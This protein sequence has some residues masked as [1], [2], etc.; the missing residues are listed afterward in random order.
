MAQPQRQPPQTGP[1]LESVQHP[2][3]SLVHADRV[4]D[5]LYRANPEQQIPLETICESVAAAS[6]APDVITFFRHIPNQAYNRR[7]LITALNNL[8]RERGREKHV[9]LFGVGQ[10][11]Q[12]AEQEIHGTPSS[13]AKPANL[14]QFEGCVQESELET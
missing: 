10:A 4:I 3:P 11:N 9:G 14:K 7:D 2:M 12:E 1:E 6:V 5:Q 13:S 8:I